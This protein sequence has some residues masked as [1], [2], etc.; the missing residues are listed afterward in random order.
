VTTLRLLPAAAAVMDRAMNTAE[1]TSPD[2]TA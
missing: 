2:P 1:D